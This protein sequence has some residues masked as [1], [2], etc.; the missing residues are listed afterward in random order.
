MTLLGG[1][2]DDSIYNGYG[3]DVVLGDSGDDWI[4]ADYG[5]DAIDGGDGTDTVY[6]WGD[7]A[8]Q[9]IF[10]AADNTVTIVSPLGGVDALHDVEFVAVYSDGVIRYNLSDLVP[11]LPTANVIGGTAGEDALHGTAAN[12][13]I[14]GI[15]GDDTITAGSGR[16]YRECGC[17][18][19]CDCWRL[20]NDII[21]AGD[22]HD[23]VTFAG[24]FF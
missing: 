24:E 14:N 6:L 20:G 4:S 2:G 18:Q 5:G 8:K 15:D 13:I 10:R 11:T 21:D 19:R 17:R 9:T 23:T 16:R 3:D 7:L 1:A 22:G 12:D